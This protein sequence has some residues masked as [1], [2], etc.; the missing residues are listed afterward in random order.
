[1]KDELIRDRVVAGI[2]DQKLSEALQ[3]DREL[4]LEKAITKVRMKEEVKM[5]QAV[6]RGVE[7]SDNLDRIYS[8]RRGRGRQQSYG[9][10][11]QRAKEGTA[12]TKCCSRCGTA[13]QHAFSL[14]PAKQSERHKCKKKG[15]WTAMCRKKVVHEIKKG[16]NENKEESE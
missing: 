4:T 13:P 9:V 1:M 2:R 11:R 3:C 12:T 10:P 16:N 5:Q 7:A 6:L 15:H 14:C 8:L